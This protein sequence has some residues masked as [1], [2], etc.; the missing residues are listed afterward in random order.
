VG[1][2]SF[3]H[4][5]HRYLERRDE[6]AHLDRVLILGPV[7]LWLGVKMAVD[8][9]ADQPVDASVSTFSEVGWGIGAF[10]RVGKEMDSKKFT[11]EC[12]IVQDVE[13]PGS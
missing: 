10:L 2:L 5:R 3:E 1:A 12:N 13:L 8:E 9:G 7:A 6:V 4:L 11:I